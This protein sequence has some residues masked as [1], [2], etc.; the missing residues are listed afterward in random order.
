MILNGTIINAIGIVLGAS[1]GLLIKGGLPKKTTELITTGLGIIIATIGIGY[2]LKSKALLVVIFSIIIGSLIGELIDIEA[3]IERF[4][5]FAENKMSKLG[6]GFSAGFVTTSILYC[7]GSMAILGSLQ[8]GLENKHDILYA[9]SLMDA[10][11]SIVFAS[12]LG[13]GVIFSSV[14]VF[15]YQGALTLLSGSVASF[16]GNNIIVEMTATG[17]ILLIG[18]GLNLSEIKK[19][20]VGNMLPAIFL[21]PLFIPLGIF[22]IKFWTLVSNSFYSVITR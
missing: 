12:T 6:K 17:G 19:I 20:K 10:V 9:K 7:V 4:A 21:P 5:K 15:I 8:S 22:L 13:Y 16:I 11:L 1:L 3:N 2:A 14:P 18:I